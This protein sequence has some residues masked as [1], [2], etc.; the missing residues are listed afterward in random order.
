MNHSKG[1]DR[2]IDYPKNEL[3]VGFGVV[4]CS[5]MRSFLKDRVQQVECNGSAIEAQDVMKLES[6][7]NLLLTKIRVWDLG[8]E[9][10]AKWYYKTPELPIPHGPIGNHGTKGVGIFCDQA[11]VC[12][13]ISLEYSTENLDL[14]VDSFY[15]QSRCIQTATLQTNPPPLQVEDPRACM[16]ECQV[17]GNQLAHLQLRE[18]DVLECTCGDWNMVPKE[19]QIFPGCLSCPMAGFE[20]FEC[21]LYLPGII[22]QTSVYVLDEET[23][24]QSLGFQYF[25]CFEFNVLRKVHESLPPSL[26]HEIRVQEPEDCFKECD[27]SKLDI[28]IISN[29]NDQDFQCTCLSLF[30]FKVTEIDD[31]C[32]NHWCPR[33]LGPCVDTSRPGVDDFR[34]ST[35]YCRNSQCD[36]NLLLPVTESGVCERE[37]QGH[38]VADPRTLG[39]SDIYYECDYESSTDV[40]LWVQRKCNQGLFDPE[41]RECVLNCQATDLRGVQWIGLP[42]QMT[43]HA[44]SDGSGEAEWFCDGTTLHFVGDQPDRTNCIDDWVSDVEDMIGK[45]ND[46]LNISLNIL[47]HVRND[48]ETGVPGGTLLS[49]VNIIEDLLKLHQQQIMENLDKVKND[50]FVK[51]TFEVIDSLFDSSISW[52]EIFEDQTRFNASSALLSYTDKVAALTL[53]TIDEDDCVDHFMFEFKVMQVEQSI[54]TEF[55]EEQFIFQGKGVKITVPKGYIGQAVCNQ[56]L[57][58][59]YNLDLESGKMFPDFPKHSE[60][61]ETFLANEG[62]FSTLLDFSFLAKNESKSSFSQ[63][64]QLSPSDQWIQ[65][66]YEHPHRRSFSPEC[67]YWNFETGSWSSD[68]CWLDRRQSTG[69]TTVCQCEH[70][71]NF[72][73]LFGGGDAD[74]QM[75]SILS[76]VFGALSCACLAVTIFFLHWF[77]Q[78]SNVRQVVELNRDYCLLVGQVLFLTIVGLKDYFDSVSCM[79][80]TFLTHFVWILV[81]TWTALEGFFLYKALVVVF[82]SGEDH[83]R[84]IYIVSYGVSAIIVVTTL[85]VSFIRD[86]FYFREDACWLNDSYIWAFKG[87]VLVIVI[88]NMVVLVVGLRAAYMVRN[89]N[90]SKRRQVSNMQKVSGWSRNF[91]ILSNLLGITWIIG[92]FNEFSSFMQYVFIVLNSSCGIFIFL[93][94]VICNRKIRDNINSTSSQRQGWTSTRSTKTFS[95]VRSDAKSLKSRMQSLKTRV[96]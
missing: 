64:L 5:W 48:N 77:K 44:C 88:L 42:D 62:L 50:A 93:Y 19:V 4:A 35:V 67:V 40:W 7:P 47:D 16:D 55:S 22:D 9:C 76:I 23:Y 20:R 96:A 53:A 74:D 92:F 21:G 17:L 70:L 69:K 75:K 82:D 66:E 52:I 25:Q 51:A 6:W 33:I 87:P 45:E 54:Y 10:F 39:G 24:A 90:A 91:V 83:F 41:L 26:I 71:T 49:T 36:A 94:G 3:K 73:I 65:I 58:V 15:R 37:G 57:G 46:S 1:L 86:D 12:D 43:Y 2:C 84:F 78:T 38:Q 11:D 13:Q 63:E 56:G 32:L 18:N 79:I 31:D 61:S 14:P 27:S 95:N 28:A 30:R 72:A 80:I 85:V 81:F 34:I 8:E 29:G 59:S 68:G 60:G 89:S